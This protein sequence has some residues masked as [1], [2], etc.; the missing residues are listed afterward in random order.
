MSDLELLPKA[1]ALLESYELL[2]R[3]W[4]M[5]LGEVEVIP[6]LRAFIRRVEAEIPAPPAAESETDD[7]DVIEAMHREL[8]EAGA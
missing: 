6:I 8:G 1:K 2:E 3:F 4:L 7:D 5:P